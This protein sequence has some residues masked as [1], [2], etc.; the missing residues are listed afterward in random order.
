M[1]IRENIKYILKDR[2]MTQVELA[3]KMGVSKQQIQSY[4]SRNA[5]VDSLQRIAIALDTT[6]ETIVSEVPLNLRNAPIPSRHIPTTTKLIC[7]HCGKEM[8]LVAKV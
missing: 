7:P 3:E 6:L 1:D 5:T 2:G 8:D 4:I